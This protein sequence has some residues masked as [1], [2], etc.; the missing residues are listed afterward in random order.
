MLGVAA[1]EVLADLWI[2][3]RPE[4]VQI[5][6]YL[7]R[8]AVGGKDF[9]SEAVPSLANR[10][11]IPGHVIQLLDPRREDDRPSASYRNL[12]PGCLRED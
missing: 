3:A 4:S 7:D 6:R 12:V 11:R 2:L 1:K 10:E 8:S 5:I 9:Q